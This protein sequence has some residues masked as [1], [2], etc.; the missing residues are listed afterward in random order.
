MGRINYLTN[1]P[2][3]AT[4]VFRENAL[5]TKKTSDPNHPLFGMRDNSALFFCDTDSP[6]FK[7]AHK[8]LPPSMSPKAVRHYTPLMLETVRGT[9]K[10]FDAFDERG[11]AFNVYQYMVKLSSQILGKFVLGMD[12]H[13]WDS[14]ASPPHRLILL[15]LKVVELNKKVQTRG[16]WY[17]YLP[18]GRHLQ[19]TM[20]KLSLLN[21]SRCTQ[22]T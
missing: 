22:T 17:S 14:I 2:E 20:H 13:H 8:F 15:L 3:M 6:A 1:D 11:L 4:Y 16:D 9:F 7:L 18:F 10:V 5:F 19:S 21:N 12:F